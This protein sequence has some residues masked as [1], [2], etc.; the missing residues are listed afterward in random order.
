MN[1]KKNSEKKWISSQLCVADASFTCN[2]YCEHCHNPP[3]GKRYEAEKVIDIIRKE[4][5]YAVSLEGMGEPLVNS[6]FFNIVEG[7]RKVGVKYISVSTNGVALCDIKFAQKVV[8]YVDFLIINFPSH[9][10]EIY[11]QMTRSV[12]Y[13]LA[14]KALDNIKTL[15]YLH[16][17]RIFHIITGRNYIY[18]GDFV[19]WLKKNYP[20]IFMLN[21]CYVRN[22]GRVK[23]NKSIIPPY[24][25]TSKFI[26]LALAK[27]KLYGFKTVIQN[28]P[29]CVIDGF[30]G[31]SFEFHR[32]KRGDHVFEKGVEEPEDVEPCQI[33]SLKPACCGARK[34]YVSVYGYGELKPSKKDLSQI[35]EERF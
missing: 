35:K 32:F 30:E 19:E 28:T 6:D 25:K 33:C 20:E 14:V 26:K 1:K 31:F 11:N 21:L 12:K 7:A 29:L 23:N 13:E 4:K 8:K 27:S 3:Q 10:K 5:P 24:T 22:K 15:G 2:L 34:D 17:T 18:L 9:L 16:I